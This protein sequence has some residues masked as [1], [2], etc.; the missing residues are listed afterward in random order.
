MKNGLLLLEEM[1]NRARDYGLE[2]WYNVDDQEPYVH[3]II[4]NPD[5]SR[6]KSYTVNIP[7]SNKKKVE[8]AALSVISDAVNTLIIKGE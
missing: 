5:N 6:R 7:I 1:T 2:C 3:C 8:D 4:V